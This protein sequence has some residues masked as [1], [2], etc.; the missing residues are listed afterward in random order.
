MQTERYDL[1]CVH[2]MHSL[3]RTQNK[4]KIELLLTEENIT[5]LVTTITGS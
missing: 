3:Q 1:L 5:F 2:F 4:H